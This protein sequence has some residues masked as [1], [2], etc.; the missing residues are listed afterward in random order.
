[1]PSPDSS[2]LAGLSVG[3]EARI[4]A[5]EGAPDLNRRLREMGLTVGTRVR[6]VRVAPLGDPLELAVR[7]YRLSVRRSEVAGIVIAPVD[8]TD[9]CD[10]SRITEVFGGG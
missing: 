2:R 7:G 9:S 8:A 4:T 6:L 3:Q 10:A 5:V 1:M